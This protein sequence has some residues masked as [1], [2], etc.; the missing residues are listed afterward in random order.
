MTSSL[1]VS[2]GEVSES[3]PTI[4][5]CSLQFSGNGLPVGSTRRA[6]LNDYPNTV[7]LLLSHYLNFSLTDFATSKQC[8][9][10]F[11]IHSDQQ[12]LDTKISSLFKTVITVHTTSNITSS[13]YI[14]TDHNIHLMIKISI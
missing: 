13:Q 2:G 8:M 5:G 14:F 7:I 11:I 3:V 9:I 10:H 12:I 4:G 1:S 6:R